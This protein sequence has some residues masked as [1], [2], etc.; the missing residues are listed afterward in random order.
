MSRYSLK[1]FRY[2]FGM[3][4]VYLGSNYLWTSFESL[5]LPYE[6][7]LLLPVDVQAIYLGL[8][9]FFGIIIGIAFNFISGTLS[10]RIRS[11]LGKRR[12]MILLGSIIVVFAL[13]LFILIKDS[14][15]VIFIIYI[16]I[17]IGS[18]I[19]YG[20]Y[21]PL[22]RDVIPP[23]QRGASS[24]IGGFFTLI[25][26][27]LGFGLSGLLI[28]TGRIELASILILITII[29][30][31]SVTVLTIKK[32]DYISNSEII[33]RRLLKVLRSASKSGKFKWMAIANFFITIGSSGL[34]F[35]EYY[36]FEYALGLKNAAIYVAISGVSILVVSAISTVA[37]GILSDRINK[38][39]LLLSFPL[40]SGFS[41]FFISFIHLFYL[42]LILGSIIGIAYGNYFTITN[43]YLSFIV[44]HG[45]VGKYLAIFLVSTEIGAAFSPLIYGIVLYIFRSTGTLAYSRL[46]EL[47]SI[48]YFLG[49]ILIFLKVVNRKNLIKNPGIVQ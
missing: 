35:F 23:S 17:E 10:D 45:S 7:E 12:P 46:F 20:S 40:I 2:I 18:N 26:S 34:V 48:F 13:V 24:G 3:N 28:G 6:I 29:A 9:A 8:I 4:S 1:S 16:L 44:P 27:A 21:R 36:Y 39:V 43:S 5:F 30:G 14:L 41:I 25:G 32:E 19:A 38:D 49:F 11:R 31:A 22:I 47:S 42:F 37:I 15:T 33:S